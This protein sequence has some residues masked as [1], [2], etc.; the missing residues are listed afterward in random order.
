MK[1]NIVS[2]RRH[3]WLDE[4]TSWFVEINGVNTGG[5]IYNEK[6]AVKTAKILSEKLGFE[7]NDKIKSTN[8]MFM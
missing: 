4:S 8:E 1:K 2:V 7:Y 6:E 5:E 3:T